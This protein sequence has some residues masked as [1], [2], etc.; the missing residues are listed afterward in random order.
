MRE[1]AQVL[2]N[3]PRGIL[4]R[5]LPYW[6]WDTKVWE[7]DKSLCASI[8]NAFKLKAKVKYETEKFICVN[9]NNMEK[10]NKKWD[11]CK[12]LCTLICNLFI[13]VIILCF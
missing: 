3:T 5:I 2:S 8:I 1:P 12:G 9:T 4:P 7:D 13:S 10:L 6:R 11:L